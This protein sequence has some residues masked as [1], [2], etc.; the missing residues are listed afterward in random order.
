[1][2]GQN[3]LF[4][5]YERIQSNTPKTSKDGLNDLKHALNTNRDL[6]LNDKGYQKLFEV[7]FTTVTRDKAVY[8][9]LKKKKA[10]VLS[11][12]ASTVRIAIDHGVK[13]LRVKSVRNLTQHIIDVLPHQDEG[14]FQPISMDYVRSL[15]TILEHSPHIEHLSQK[16]WIELVRFCCQGMSSDLGLPSENFDTESGERSRA[17][18]RAP[19]SRN[20][21]SMSWTSLVVHNPR[22]KSETEE[23]MLCLQL[24]LQIPNAPIMSLVQA[25]LALSSD[26]KTEIPLSHSIM[27]FLKS[28]PNLTSAHLA[29]F[30]S[31]NSFLATVSTNNIVIARKIAEGLPAV[32]TKLWESKSAFALKEQ[33]L[34]S[35]IYSFPHLRSHIEDATSGPQ[36]NLNA[37][38]TNLENLL[39]SL[40]NEYTTG[41][42]RMTRE[43]LQLDEIEFPDPSLPVSLNR[44]PLS[45]KAFSLRPDESTRSEQMWMVLQLIARLI[46][47][48]DESLHQDSSV[49]LVDGVSESEG[50]A[51]RRQSKRRKVVRKCDDILHQASSSVPKSK[52]VALQIIPFLL[53]ER[54][55]A[56]KNALGDTEWL[57]VMTDLSLVISEDNTTSSSWA[58]L[59]IANGAFLRPASQPANAQF[60]SQIWNLCSRH[61][62]NQATCRAACHLMRVILSKNLIAYSS[63]SQII[64]DTLL[65][66]DLNG[67]AIIVDSAFELWSLILEKRKSVSHSLR[68]QPEERLVQWFIARWRPVEGLE[69]S[70]HSMAQLPSASAILAFLFACFGE[71][72]GIKSQISIPR[73][74]GQI[75]RAWIRFKQESKLLSYLLLEENQD[76]NDDNIPE[77]KKISAAVDGSN[78]TLSLHRNASAFIIDFLDRE[79]I[80]IE[81]R[82]QTLLDNNG[83]NISP[84]VLHHLAEFVFIAAAVAT[85]GKLDMRSMDTLT[86]RLKTISKS[87]VAYLERP[88]CSES[89]INAILDCVASLLPNSDEVTRLEL[90]NLAVYD[91]LFGELINSISK[92]VD[93]RLHSNEEAANDLDTDME[94]FDL[95]MRKRTGVSAKEPDMIPRESLEAAHSQDAARGCT[96][97]LLALFAQFWQTRGKAPQDFGIGFSSFLM[98][99]PIQRLILIKP[100]IH[101]FLSSTPNLPADL[102]VELMEHFGHSMLQSYDFDRCETSLDLV[103]DSIQALAPKW[104]PSNADEVLKDRCDSIYG[105]MTDV[106]LENQMSSPTLRINMAKALQRMLTMDKIFKHADKSARNSFIHLLKDTD[107][108][109]KLFMADNVPQ[110]FEIYPLNEHTELYK[111]IHECLHR[112]VEWQEGLAMRCYTLSKLVTASHTT[113]R[114]V[115]YYMFETAIIKGAEKYA[116]RCAVL[117]SKVL[118]LKG[119]QELFRMFSSQLLYTWIR[120][121]GLDLP[122]VVCGYSSATELFQDV[123]EELVAQLMMNDMDTQAEF[124]AGKLEVSFEDLLTRSFHRIISYG[125]TLPIQTPPQQDGEKT[126]LVDQRVRKRLGEKSY[127]DLVQSRFP[128]VV[129]TLFQSMEQDGTSEKLLSR[130]ASLSSAKYIMHDITSIAV[131]DTVLP[132]PL[133]PSF[134]VKVVL[135]A[136]H[137]ICRKWGY[138]GNALWGPDMFAFVARKLFDTIDPGL[139]PLH[140]CSVIRKIRL[141]VCLAGKTVHEGYPLEMLI[142]GL[143]PFIVD[144]FCAQDT[145]GIMQ[146]L[147]TCG[148]THLQTNPTFVVGTFLSIMASLRNFIGLT[149]DPSQTD[150]SQ[151]LGSQSTAQSFNTWLCNYLSD[152]TSA[153][154]NPAN[155]ETF[156]AIVDSAIGF[157][158]N[159][160]AL[161]GTKESELLR[162]LLQDEI[163]ANGLLDDVS[164]NLAFSLISSNF[165]KPN[166][167]REDMYG[168]DEASISV[169]KALLRTCQS[170]NVSDGYLLWSARV[171]GRAYAATG[172]VHPEWT[173]ESELPQETTL[174]ITNNGLAIVPKAAILKLL[175]GL[176]FSENRK[177]V[178]LAEI[179]LIDILH[180]EETT[181]TLATSE[182]VLSS[183]LRKAFRWEHPPDRPPQVSQEIKPLVVAGEIGDLPF[184]EWVKRFALTICRSSPPDAVGNRVGPL[185]LSVEGLAEKIFPYLVHILLIDECNVP[186][187]KLR[188]SLS[189]AF[190]KAF[191]ARSKA[192]VPHMILLIK[193]IL[194]LRT[195]EISSENTKEDR[196][197]WLELD[198]ED[199]ARAA[200]VCKMYKTALLFAEIYFTRSSADIKSCTDLLLE[201]YKNTDDP[202]S[203]YGLKQAAS[204]GSVLNKL[205]YEQDGWKSLSFRGAQMESSMRRGAGFSAES[206]IGVIE[207]LNNLG[208]NGLSYSFLQGNTS[209]FGNEANL[210]NIYES[211]WKLEQWNIP[212]PSSYTGQGATVYRALQSINN[213]INTN[214]LSVRLDPPLLDIM[215]QITAG[216]QTGHSLGASIRT[217][218]MLT[219]VE[220][221]LSS[222]SPV[223]VKE[224]W[225]RFDSRTSWMK[226][227]NFS[228]V[229]EILSI[230]QSTFGSITKRLHLQ[231]K[232]QLPLKAARLYEASSL[233]SIC[234]LSRS[235][236]VLQHSLSAAS[237]LHELVEPCQQI[238]LDISAAATLQ[239]ASVLWEQGETTASIRML[240]DLDKT[241]NLINRQEITP[242]RAQLLSTTAT[243]ISEARLEKPEVIMGNY[244]EPAIIEIQKGKSKA[245][246]AGRVFHEFAVFCDQQLNAPNN[247][248]DYERV[249]KLRE[250]K[251]AEIAEAE[252][253]LRLNPKNHQL[254]SFLSKAKTWL[255]LDE[256]ELNRIRDNREIFL[257]KSL[258]NYL[259]SLEVCDTY[260]QDAIRFCAL[261][262]QY[263]TNAKANRVV[264]LHLKKV[265][266]RKFVPLM[267]QLSSRLVESAEEFQELLFDL[268]LRICRD[269]PFHS[270]YQIFTIGKG[271]AKDQ[272]SASRSVASKLVMTL[273]KE[274]TFTGQTIGRI[275]AATAIYIRLAGYKIVQG[276]TNKFALRRAFPQD[277]ALCTKIERDL[278]QLKIPPPTMNIEVRVD[279]D[280]SN[281]PFLQRFNPELS[282]AGGLSAPKILTCHDSAGQSYKMLVKGGN[283]DL[284]QDA[285]MEQVFEQVS[286]ILQKNRQARQRNL[287]IR[288][289][290]VIPLSYSAGV[291]EFVP[292]TIPLHD[293]LLPAHQL[294]HPH[295]N[296]PKICR[297]GIASVAKEPVEK[298]IAK[299]LQ[300]TSKFNPVMKYFFM[301][302]FNGPDEW[303]RSRLAYTRSTAAISILGYVLGLGDRH[304]QNILLD[305]KSG[306]VVHIDLG[307]AFEQGRILPVPETVPFRLTRDIV[308]GM[309]ITGTEGVFRRCCEFTLSVLRAEKESIIT[310]LDVLRYDPLYSWTI[311]PV[312]KQRMQRDEDGKIKEEADAN[313]DLFVKPDA[314]QNEE[315]EA[316][317]ALAVVSRKLTQTLSVGAT[318]NEL[319]Q[320][321]VDVKNLAVLYS[322]WGAYA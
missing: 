79:S 306:E 184:E 121:H 75:S 172:V 120:N 163:E 18:S 53:E 95:P 316:E 190:R 282:V 198:Y 272:S 135:T 1:M 88:D 154:M 173:Q 150:T 320:Q 36:G 33:M 305:E 203:F 251:Q 145:V 157:K 298:R 221:V 312:R 205:E 188:E 319:I 189:K 179:S 186:E 281:L 50:R 6:N 288:T 234:E 74:C 176:L 9:R 181:E 11:L 23:L 220:E 4:A 98:D 168:A 89:H 224:V 262:L 167:Y 308:D 216:K 191:R 300:I 5:I 164:K 113:K 41:T 111:D 78:L 73:P 114:Q 100:I 249:S 197:T 21:S 26:E 296:T 286:L 68:L 301:Y 93:A 196:E 43:Q 104:I 85:V 182:L 14:L 17:A 49:E 166:S 226:I 132:G 156:K 151:L 309:G 67:P 293:F 263:S 245:E 10:D 270:L 299:F 22:L 139:G 117:V 125:T 32:I 276:K 101:S 175:T 280:Y 42:S 24:L 109:V 261:W 267:N 80:N 256:A 246:V 266:S 215:K 255:R 27:N 44:H 170:Y 321:A 31:L 39:T 28:Q 208:L 62:T 225:K 143:R 227:G 105:W 211:A 260:D 277:T 209:G 310:I 258:G 58:M 264:S 97:A 63:I 133:K 201:I 19:V 187:E 40:V 13:I 94:D 141:L 195:Q 38:R 144:P 2:S 48:L 146:Y 147:F 287:G 210:E 242:E 243:W 47:L 169:S 119:P 96:V 158:G 292:N 72:H 232:T 56:R 250:T 178:G 52:L 60:W 90:T 193:T 45:L 122:Y 148:K 153:N 69:R 165:E 239:A 8:L 314:N 103:L 214:N 134:K 278:P 283:D 20:S 238:G 231:N 313:D 289:Y 140:A 294:Y 15:R 82:W 295:E 161:N 86:E 304:G 59:G 240:Q 131:S 152:Y 236:K 34:I 160:N 218:A 248:E 311:S 138:D 253:L 257:Q 271:K 118:G 81:D 99:L 291:I 202:D 65:S 155:T 199:L 290:K 84:T 70:T 192:S 124:V 228:D 115:V 127:N 235:H 7:I 194:Y 110:L 230:R 219:E 269:H 318:V 207:S 16:E 212:C 61:A 136:L 307:V 223:Q 222:E 46:L 108:R 247:I 87:L 130:D 35:L 259:R 76:E 112:E 244:L 185:L 66:M 183:H 123:Q 302:N 55:E 137:H 159:G 273:K 265:A 237:Q 284:R 285:I 275:H 57:R 37:I 71:K 297:E 64:D 142:H 51:K 102:C 83:K 233:I 315:A 213:N 204:L 92:A 128:L 217:L 279:C 129:A 107:I 254:T 126:P 229:E 77:A 12:A 206:G 162:V 177:E 30:S 317:R 54:C 303:F 116:A 268:T 322:G 25:D 241:G 29:A 149:V 91:G 171:L 252:K 274:Q 3:D 174:S 200:C 106:C 180:E